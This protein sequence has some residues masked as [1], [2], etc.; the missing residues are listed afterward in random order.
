MIAFAYLCFFGAI[1]VIRVLA[2]GCCCWL[3]AVAVGCWL[4]LSA[5]AVGCWPLLLA[6]AV[7]A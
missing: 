2:V 7:V 5:V 3:L 4:L 1:G 6:V